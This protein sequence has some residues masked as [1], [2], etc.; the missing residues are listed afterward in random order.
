MK[1]RRI[2]LRS[3]AFE[4]GSGSGRKKKEKDSYPINP[5]VLGLFVF[6]V[7]GSAIV[8]IL[9]SAQGASLGN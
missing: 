2:G 7:V 4:K 1:D 3:Q 5:W 6:V 8:Q 9:S